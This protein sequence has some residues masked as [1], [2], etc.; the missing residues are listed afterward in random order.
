MDSAAP[1]PS[2][3]D[4]TAETTG[5]DLVPRRGGGKPSKLVLRLALAVTEAHEWFGIGGVSGRLRRPRRLSRNTKITL[6]L[7]NSGGPGY[8]QSGDHCRRRIVRKMMREFRK[9]EEFR[10]LSAADWDEAVPRDLEARIAE[11]ASAMPVGDGACKCKV[12]VHVRVGF[13][14]REATALL[15]ACIDAGDLA[16]RSASGD[17]GAAAPPCSICFE[18]MARDAEATAC[19]P[20][21]AHGFHG[22]CIGKWFEKASTCPVCRRD[23]LQYLPPDY[24][25]V[26]DIMRSDPEGSC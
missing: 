2:G 5:L 18:E 14:Y 8:L 26:H 6:R 16:S 21:C 4:I 25:A 7:A 19:L 10:G 9:E 17:D 1:R 3:Y 13:V 11:R 24:R 23:K 12:S 15:R 22:R 20:G